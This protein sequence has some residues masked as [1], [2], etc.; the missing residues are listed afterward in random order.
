MFNISQSQF[1][2]GN[3]PRPTLPGAQNL[4]KMGF[5]PSSSNMIAKT[6]QGM[7]GTNLPR[8]TQ[9][10]MGNLKQLANVMRGMSR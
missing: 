8:Q 2:T 9:G 3:T 5:N 10:S 1:G 6:M 7:G 4:P